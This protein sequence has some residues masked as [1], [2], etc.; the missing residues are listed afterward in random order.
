MDEQK[1]GGGVYMRGG[2]LINCIIEIIQ[3]TVLS[4][5]G[6]YIHMKSNALPS[7]VISITT[8]ELLAEE[9]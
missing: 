5:G 9:L 6:V 3:A 1:C 7:I 4:G 2:K 8:K